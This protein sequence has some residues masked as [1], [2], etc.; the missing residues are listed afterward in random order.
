MIDPTTFKAFIYLG[1]G[2]LICG[3][4]IVGVLAIRDCF[5]MLKTDD[6]EKQN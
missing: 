3:T 1:L 2:W 6:S 4:A 5:K